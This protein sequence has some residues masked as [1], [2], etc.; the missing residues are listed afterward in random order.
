MR[1]RND[2]SRGD[3]AAGIG[4]G[5]G[6]NQMTMM[7]PTPAAGKR[8]HEPNGVPPGAPHAASREQADG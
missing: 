7:W 6:T 2:K 1:V 4:F 3:S 8:A 5:G